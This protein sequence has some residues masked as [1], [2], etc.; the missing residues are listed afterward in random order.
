[1]SNKGIVIRPAK[2]SD[3]AAIQELFVETIE[4]VCRHDYSPEQIAV[5]TSS[6]ENTK[7]WTDKLMKQYF[8][9]AEIDHKIVGFASLENNEYF[10]FMYVHKDYQRQGIADDLYSE[11]LARAIKK[12]S[13]TVLTSDVS[14]TARPF[15]EK[16][17]FKIIAEQ[18]NDIKGVEVMNYKMTKELRTEKTTNC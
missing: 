2:L 10:D 3:L 9:I 11:I 14:I 18:K 5:W 15:F 16:K 8:I 13:T 12:Q 7:R 17:G 6:V 1:M 4:T